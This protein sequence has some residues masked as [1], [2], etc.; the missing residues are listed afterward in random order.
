MSE[1]IEL[2]LPL[3]KKGG[4]EFTEIRRLQELVNFY[5]AAN[6][7]G[8]Q[9]VVDGDFGVKTEEAVRSVQRNVGLTVDG[10]VGSRTWTFLLSNWLSNSLD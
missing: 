1:K 4:K 10:I 2:T 9:L 6:V 3:L 8:K 5:V 7:G